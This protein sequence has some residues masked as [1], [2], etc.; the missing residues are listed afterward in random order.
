M[1]VS[2]CVKHYSLV[3][4]KH[5]IQNEDVR[6]MNHDGEWFAAPDRSTAASL[7]FW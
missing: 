1:L 4:V 6:A 7:A 2:I 5:D 3:R